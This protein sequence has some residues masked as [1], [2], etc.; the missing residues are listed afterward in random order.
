MINSKQLRLISPVISVLNADKIAPLLDK[1]CPLY[2][3]AT[4]D[5]FEEFLPNILHES[6][7]FTTLVE[8]LNY[9]AVA[10]TKLFGRHRI[11]IDDCYRYGRTLKQT[12][13]Q[14]MIANILYGGAWG[15]TNLGNILPDDGWNLRG[16]GPMQIT[17]RYLGTKF[18]NYY[19]NRFMIGYSITRVFDLLRTD[20]SFG[21]HAACWLFAIEKKL[22]DE[23]IDDKMLAIRKSINGGTFGMDEV[24]RFYS[25]C[26]IF[27]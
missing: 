17:G 18:M 1:I 15:K 12:A 26:K 24:N 5:I 3:I 11:S 9:Q 21:I 19:N 2:G 23:A 25:N 7:S 8:S 13:N 14:K 27:L 16:S 22:I 6:G 10:L 20:I 4:K